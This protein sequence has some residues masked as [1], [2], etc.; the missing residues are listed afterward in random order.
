V[1]CE[2]SV[3]AQYLLTALCGDSDCRAFRSRA[4]PY[5]VVKTHRHSLLAGS[6]YN[7]FCL[8]RPLIVN[9]GFGFY[10][11]TIQDDL[12]NLIFNEDSHGLCL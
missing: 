11:I 7:L 9:G 6:A 2:V 5:I 3:E 8:L 1:A 10:R 12:A 4:A